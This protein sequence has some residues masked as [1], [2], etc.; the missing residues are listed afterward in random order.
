[1]DTD[2]D[3]AE[4][5]YQAGSV[6]VVSRPAHGRVEVDPTTNAVT[7]IPATGFGGTDSFRYT[8]TDDAGATSNA[9]TAFFRGNRPT[10]AADEAETDGTTPV[11][12]DVLENDTDPDGKDKIEHPGSVTIVR[13]PAHGTVSV[14]PTTNEV[15]F[16]ARPGFVGTDTFRYTVTD[17]AGATSA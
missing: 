15:T 4:H 7:Y 14:D 8:V 17:D 2:P 1:N 9:A 11:V 3:G 12:I 16:T 5:I 13:N 6:R 10:D